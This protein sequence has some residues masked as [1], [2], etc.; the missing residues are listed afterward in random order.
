MRKIIIIDNYAFILGYCKEEE[1][2]LV[3]YQPISDHNEINVALDDEYAWKVEDGGS[4]RECDSRMG[5][6]L[7]EIQLQLK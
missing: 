4:W 2:D 6:D 3:Y 1:S 7:E 5:Y